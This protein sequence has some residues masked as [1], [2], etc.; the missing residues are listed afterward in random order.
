MSWKKL[1]NEAPEKKSSKP[2]RGKKSHIS[3][4]VARK[5]NGKNV[6]LSYKLLQVVCKKLM[7]FAEN[8]KKFS[9]R[10]VSDLVMDMQKI[11]L[12]LQQKNTR[13]LKPLLK[14]KKHKHN[15]NN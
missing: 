10:E 11:I 12:K 9:R 13:K 8:E 15:K 5:V 14:P 7:R 2:A 4:K 3:Q 6:G 1:P